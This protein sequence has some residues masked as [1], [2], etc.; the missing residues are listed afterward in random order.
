[1]PSLTWRKSDQRGGVIRLGS[2]QLPLGGVG[3]RTYID[4]MPKPLLL[5]IMRWC[6]LH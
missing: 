5:T 6:F 2:A 1:M 3:A 4:L